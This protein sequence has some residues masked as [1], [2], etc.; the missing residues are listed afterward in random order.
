ML[1]FLVVFGH[2]I[3]TFADT[4][5]VDVIYKIIFSFHMPAFIFV[6]G[7][8]AKVDPKKILSRIFP[9][10]IVFQLLRFLLD[11]ILDSIQWG[12]PVKIDMQ[13]FTPRWTLWYLVAM[14]I[15]QLLLPVFD[16]KNKRHRVAY[17]LLSMVLGI[18]IG[19]NPDTENFMAMS[20]I[21]NFLPFFL[22]GYYEKDGGFFLR[23][24]KQRNPKEAKIATAFLAVGII[25]GFILISRQSTRKL[26]WGTESF[27]G[28]VYTWYTRILAWII[29]FL[30]IWIL[31]VWV[32]TR[33]IP[34]IETIGKNTLSV[35]L[36]HTIV[37][38]ILM[39][40]PFN[41]W[42]F[43]KIGWQLLISVGLTLG[44]SWNGFERL[45]RKIA[46]PYYGNQK[47]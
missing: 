6:S 40:T 34:V 19:Y 26:F 23:Y 47:K 38:L 2:M 27:D 46:I 15:Y 44:L 37:I 20:R 12:H 17:L 24:G 31:I 42:V 36:L 30:W 1:I 32:P 7:Y 25:A 13:F 9:L 5:E 35:Y 3:S 11:F 10:Y 45:L 43:N 8:F 21:M 14:I 29:A 4:P 33:R 18:V 39:Y 41:D 16:T 22:A 28:D